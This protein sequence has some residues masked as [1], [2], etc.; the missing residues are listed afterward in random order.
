MEDVR[1]TGP[2]ITAIPEPSEK[3]QLVLELFSTCVEHPGWTV[4]VQA[5]RAL[6]EVTGFETAGKVL[7]SK[8]RPAAVGWWVS[9]GRKDRRIP[10]SLDAEE[11][12]DDREEFY[13]EV[14]RWW[15]R[16]NPGWR[17]EGLDSSLLSLE[18]GGS[19][20]RAKGL[21]SGLNGLTSVLACLWWWHRL[22]GVEDGT[23]AW[24]NL[25]ED[26]TWVLTEKKRVLVGKRAISGSSGEQ[27]AKRKR[28]A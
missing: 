15:V 17:K 11:K 7:P 9:R 5:W 12:E 23:T 19:S 27:P 1:T 14:V 20:E 3:H 8:E 24:K 10:C 6:E 4:A 16:I 22:A 25:L 28:T 13:E 2:S 26:V 18:K 21:F